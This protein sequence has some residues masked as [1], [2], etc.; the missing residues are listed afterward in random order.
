MSGSNSMW[1]TTPCLFVPAALVWW[2]G[3]SARAER[4]KGGATRWSALPVRILVGVLSLTVAVG[5]VVDVYRIGD[6]G[7]KAAWHDAY[8]KAPTRSRDGS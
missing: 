2:A 6:S 3:R 4:G 7:A 1:T 8:S 5:A